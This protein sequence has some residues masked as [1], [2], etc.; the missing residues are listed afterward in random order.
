MISHQLQALCLLSLL[1]SASVQVRGAIGEPGH[2][3][4]GQGARVWVEGRRLMVEGVGPYVMR[5]VVW[6]P[7]G[8]GTGTTPSAADNVAVRRAELHRWGERD[9]PLIAA[10]HANTVRLVMDPGLG[11]VAGAAGQG[12][13]DRLY[14][15]GIRV[16]MNVDD[17]VNDLDRIEQAVVAYRDHP[18]ILMW[19]LGSEWNLNLYFGLAATPL[20]AAQRTER[21]AAL[22]RRLD[23]RHP[24]AASLGDIHIDADGR[25]LEDT[26]TY[27]NQV[28]PSVDL[29]GLNVYR[30][31]SFGDLFY[32]WAAI[33]DKP[34]FL[35]EFGADAFH[36]L[37]AFDTLEGGGSPIGRLDEAAQAD[38]NLALWQ[39]IQA[40]LSADH[41]D[42]VAVGGTVFEWNDEWWKVPPPGA[43]DTGGVVAP[44]QQPD[45]F[46]NEE[47]F[48]VVR[49]DRS[50]RP[51]YGALRDAFAS[52]GQTRHRA[53]SS[54]PGAVPPSAANP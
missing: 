34:V 43:Q 1:A 22:V 27:V 30:G 23:P 53:Q 3:P 10:M 45:H 2:S 31:R 11:P 12:L 6:S 32:Q 37:D 47:W 17:G 35:G 36:T 40:N 50:L 19:M 18:A 16:V 26:R 44:G 4:V 46:A 48:G 13:L 21:A 28:C 54:D 24:V 7:A 20:E 38:W 9:V 42:R 41:P 15:A 39:E 25:R 52:D 8:P 14:A 33:S 51:A 5:G 49:I 29:W